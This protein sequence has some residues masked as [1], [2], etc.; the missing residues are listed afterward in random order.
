MGK[1]YHFSELKDDHFLFSVESNNK[2]VN[3][4]QQV[5]RL[6]DVTIGKV[7]RTRQSPPEI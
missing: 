3:Q 7:R 1:F 2:T 5:L 6:A 4:Y